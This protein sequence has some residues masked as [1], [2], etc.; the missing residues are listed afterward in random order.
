MLEAVV[1]KDGTTPENTT[2]IGGIAEAMVFYGAVHYVANHRGYQVLLDKI[3]SYPLLQLMEAG[4]LRLH[5]AGSQLSV[6]TS[7]QNTGLERYRV[8]Y[9]SR[10][11]YDPI[12][13]AKESF[14]KFAGSGDHRAAAH[15]FVELI[16]FLKNPQAVDTDAINNALVT[17]NGIGQEVI[18]SLQHVT[19][20]A[21]PI[22][23][24]WKAWMLG[25]EIQIGTNVDF[26]RVQKS[27]SRFDPKAAVSVAHMIA[28]YAE[29]YVDA[30]N[31]AAFSA[32]PRT[33][34]FT[35]PIMERRLA[36]LWQRSD[37]NGSTVMRFNEATFGGAKSIS[38]A[39]TSGRIEVADLIPVI[40]RG[41]QFRK[42]IAGKPFDTDLLHDYY[43]DT[44]ADSPLDELPN[45]VATFSLAS[46]I[47]VALDA[48]LGPLAGVAVSAMETFVIKRLAGGWR[49][50][51][52]VDRHLRPLVRDPAD[53]AT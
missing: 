18:A 15:R 49:P 36:D 3:G 4:F 38:E 5:V 53:S 20:D 28:H 6:H 24:K 35:A 39:I 1:F 22:E 47:G 45:K 7:A 21:L 32:E 27:L 14:A 40:E 17:G 11:K 41:T 19:P 52:Y 30:Y 48:K 42:W 43:R 23:P 51:L 50:N 13:E 31:A 2:D 46:L 34:L 25:G 8:I 29:T 9:I 16:H 37:K 33:G 12:E 26:R 44:I 10:T